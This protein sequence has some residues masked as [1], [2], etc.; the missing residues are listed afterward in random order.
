[1]PVSD[2]SFL[3]GNKKTLLKRAQAIDK[4]TDKDDVDNFL[5]AQHPYTLHKRVIRNFKR[6]PYIITAIDGL[7]ESDLADL[8]MF[9]K[10]NDGIKF[11]MV[12]I[13]V[14]T[15]Y[16]WVECLR[17]KNAATVTTAF[18]Q[19]LDRADGR[20]PVVFRSDRGKEYKNSTFSG[21]LDSRNIR[22]Q[23]PQTTSLF[24]ASIAE[25]FIKNMKLRIYRYFTSKMNKTHRYIDVL[26]DIIRAYN[27]T[28]HSTTKFRPA[29]IQ[30]HDAPTVYRNTRAKHERDLNIFEKSKPK[31]SVGDPVLVVKKRST[32][33][34]G[35]TQQFGKEV[36]RIRKIINKIPYRL[37]TLETLQRKPVE[38]KLYAQ[39]L[40]N[41]A[42]PP[43]KKIHPF[44]S[45]W[46]RIA[47]K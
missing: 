37:Y 28:V 1:M 21:F 43:A 38:G 32:F 15:K 29:A 46:K 10:E 30:P 13:D 42:E 12:V 33:H 25:A 14:F 26:Q 17:N 36:F 19:I 44:F 20:Q 4:N 16:A 8:T 3:T 27:E 22:Q 24:K 31:F 47:H 5:R 2:E 18:K 11:V 40:Q 6:N 39:E 35:Y 9:A 45:T 7:W 41:V 34:T 23:F